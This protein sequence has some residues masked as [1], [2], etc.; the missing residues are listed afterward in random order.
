MFNLLA[1]TDAHDFGVFVVGFI[2]G[3]GI[4][5]AMTVDW[6]EDDDSVAKAGHRAH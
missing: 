6:R 1:E 3:W 4:T 2:V 5:L